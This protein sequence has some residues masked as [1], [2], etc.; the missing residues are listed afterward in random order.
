MNPIC[1]ASASCPATS[2]PLVALFNICRP[3]NPP[4][5]QPSTENPSDP[6]CP[7]IPSQYYPHWVLSIDD[8]PQSDTLLAQ[9]PSPC[10]LSPSGPLYSPPFLLRLIQTT[11]TCVTLAHTQTQ[12]PSRSHNPVEE[13]LYQNL[14][15]VLSDPKL[16]HM[17]AVKRVRTTRAGTTIPAKLAITCIWAR[18]HGR[19][20]L[21]STVIIIVTAHRILGMGKGW[22]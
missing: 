7:H 10:A 22:Q 11:S 6:N 19:L 8:R 12:T 20:K 5:P 13:F 14:S 3:Y 18:C 2:Q 16:S 9:P 21:L 1:S 15:K 4:L 17:C